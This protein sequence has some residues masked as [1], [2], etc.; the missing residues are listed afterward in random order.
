[1][2][3]RG[4]NIPVFEVLLSIISGLTLI[5]VGFVAYALRD[6][7]EQTRD[8]GKKMERVIS[9]VENQAKNGE[10]L[11][12]DLNDVRNVLYSHITTDRN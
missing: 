2:T 3:V 8:L 1:M 6:S 4:E 12:S 10:E 11:R 5:I 7:N 9:Q